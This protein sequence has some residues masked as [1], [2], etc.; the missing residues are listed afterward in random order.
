MR[1]LKNAAMVFPSDVIN[2][3]KQFLFKSWTLKRLSLTEHRF[4]IP[5][6]SKKNA[7]RTLMT[8][9]VIK[10]EPSSSMSELLN[11]V[12]D[13]C[14]FCLNTNNVSCNIPPIFD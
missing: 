1:F 10:G 6:S 7:E 11:F 2:F 12:S 14:R 4:L 8:L 3:C 13:S 9:T 5:S